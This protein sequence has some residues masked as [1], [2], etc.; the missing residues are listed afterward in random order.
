MIDL[1]LIRRYKIVRV[2]DIVDALDRF[3]FHERTLISR[4]IRPL[5]SGIKIAGF[6]LTVQTRRVQE[7]I[8]TMN[9]EEYDRY[10]EEW[11]KTRANYDH[12]M[13]L[14]GPGVVI[15]INSD[16]C[17]DVGFWGSM[18]ALVAKAKG[19]EGVILDGGC[20]DISEIRCIKFPVFCRTRG[21]TEVVGRLEIKP[22]NVNV[23]TSIGGVTVNPGDIIVGDDDGVVVVPRK[24]APQ[25]LERAEKQMA[26]DRASQK[27]YLDAL[28]LTLP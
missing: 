21:R 19:V 2:A 10:A 9:S 6:A 4:K 3:G 17:L 27:S 14:A 25:V 28:G 22:E 11:Y 7:E 23:S 15:A 24:I 8:P 1:N 12:F 26:L 16:G 5:Y 18:V 13:K 20:R